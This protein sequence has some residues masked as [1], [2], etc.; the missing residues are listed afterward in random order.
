MEDL[1][2]RFRY[3]L[4]CGCLAPMSEALAYRYVLSY[5]HSTK[6][7]VN[8]K[9]NFHC[10]I[11]ICRKVLL[12]GQGVFKIRILLRGARAPTGESKQGVYSLLRLSCGRPRAAFVY[13]GFSVHTRGS[14]F[15]TSGSHLARRACDLITRVALSAEGRSLRII[16]GGGGKHRLGHNEVGRTLLSWRADKR[17]NLAS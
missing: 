13:S 7:E 15:T 3:C 5:L 11:S 12:C 6:S 16:G 4:Q 8:K 10:L 9:N 17:V 2:Q 14:Y 1:A